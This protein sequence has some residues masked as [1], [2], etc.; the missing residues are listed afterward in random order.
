LEPSSA[1]H[2]TT[3][4][5]LATGPDRLEHLTTYNAT[6]PSCMLR[7]ELPKLP[8]GAP[9][10]ITMAPDTPATV[11]ADLDVNMLVH[12]TGA[13]AT[14]PETGSTI[15]GGGGWGAGPHPPAGYYPVNSVPQERRHPPLTAQV[16]GPFTG[17]TPTGTVR[18]LVEQQ[19]VGTPR[20]G[21]WPPSHSHSARPTSTLAA[22]TPISAVLLLG[23]GNLRRSKGTLLARR[24]PAHLPSLQRL[25]SA[26][27]KNF[28]ITPLYRSG[29]A[30]PGA[31][32]TGNLLPSL[33]QRISRAS[34]H[35]TS[36]QQQPW[37]LHAFVVGHPESTSPSGNG[38]TT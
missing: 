9:S 22:A 33:R 37:F 3:L 4:Y 5:G 17:T 18:C 14:P 24:R 16:A 2:R 34:G 26:P 15:G 20:A 28:S 10:A 29:T 8:L 30:W 31:T 13:S 38:V 36:G 35:L 19:I 12:Q 1:N 27:R 6:S 7:R 21:R 32:S 11:S 23:D 25:R